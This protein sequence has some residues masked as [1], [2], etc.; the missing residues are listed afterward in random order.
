[1]YIVTNDYYLID[2]DGEPTTWGK[3]N[4]TYLNGQRTWSDVRG[5][6][7]LQVG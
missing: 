6:N 1:M 2:V 4:P 5:L 7:S 3:W